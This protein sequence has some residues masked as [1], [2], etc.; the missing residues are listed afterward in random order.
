MAKNEI[1]IQIAANAQN[2][3][4]GINSV[5]Q[6]LDQLQKATDTASSKFLRLSAGVQGAISIFTAV[7]SVVQ[8]VAEAASACVS[9]YAAQE[10]AEIR[11]QTTLKATQNAVGMS[12]SE[13]LD[14][15]ESLQKV[16]AYSD[17]EIIA[18]EGILAATRK[19]GRDVMPE[20]TRAVL[21][22]AAATGE[23]ATQA[24]ERLAQALAD[25]A[26]EIESLKEAGIQLTEKQAENVKA[27]QEQNGIYSA[28]Q[29]ILDEIAAT[30]GDMARAIADTDTGKLQKIGD[31]WTDIKE[32]L[33]EGL[34]NAISPALNTIYSQLCA[35]S[36]WINGANALE[37]AKGYDSNLSEY[38]SEA[39][40]Q[41][42]DS[43]NNWLEK[44]EDNWF[45]DDKEIAN[46]Q[47]AVKNITAELERRG[48]EGSEVGWWVEDLRQQEE[49]EKQE[50]IEKAKA[51]NSS[52][53][54]AV[55]SSLLISPVQDF[56]SL[57]NIPNFDKLSLGINPASA[58]NDLYRTWSD[59]GFVIEQPEEDSPEP[60]RESP[61]S[62]FLSKYGSLSDTRQISAIDDAIRAS[63]QFMAM[64]G[65][66]DNTKKQLE[67]INAAL[68][69]QKEALE[70]AGDA[71]EDW[72]DNF[73]EE[74]FPDMLR[75]IISVSDQIASVFDN[76][77]E[78]SAASLEE[79]E[80]KWDEYF[81]KLDRDQER[82]A[83]SLNAQLISGNISYEDYIDSMNQLDD[84]RAKAEEQAAS[85]KQA[86]EE[87][88]NRDAET[89]FR[90]RQVNAFAEAAINAALSITDIWAKYG[91]NPA[92]A[93]VLTGISAA[94]TAAEMATISSQQYT[95]MAAGGIV[96]SPTR[97][98]IGEGGSPEAILPLNEGNMNRFGLSGESGVININISIG[99]VYSKENLAEEI[100][101]GIERA[102]RTGA[103]PKWRYA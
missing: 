85:E 72:K 44:W 36:D 103:L 69:D 96:T 102:Q 84:E 66:D 92:L 8:K 88:A 7:S 57:I 13:L 22:M 97:A 2:A 95:P 15:A 82:Q 67:E 9:A 11:L 3:V 19:I 51:V 80:K 93:G 18:V 17:Q 79:I 52:A 86:E 25:P 98:L 23:D 99:E 75:G 16:T 26:G 58:L 50:R 64:P 71:A 6:K 89:A 91:S 55:S 90:I 10:Q 32:G 63:Q 61:L 76:M 49:Q 77:A 65:L 41:A 1:T 48:A 101:R 4:N 94:A 39:L 24:A 28:Q 78:S 47:R 33:G 30:Y 62:K 40:R 14:L 37:A 34:L 83:E 45:A 42:R 21:N 60:Q 29:I 74:T 54:A 31:V 68:Y 43:A 100:F 81:E 59:E 87:K 38:S 46:Y 70:E 73:A 53:N 20:A 12:A 27:V 35:I 56:S 5:N